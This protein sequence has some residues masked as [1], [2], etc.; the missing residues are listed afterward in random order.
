MRWLIGLLAVVLTGGCVSG[1]S[2]APSRPTSAAID[3]EAPRLMTA[4]GARGLAIA[5]VTDG[6]IDHVQAYGER[7]AAGQLLGPDTVMYGASLTKAVFAYTVMQLVDEGKIDLDRSIADYLPRP[8]PEY[9]DEAIEDR[10]ADFR[11]L[12][13]DPRWR[14]LTPRM[15]LTHSGGFANFGF[16]EPDGKLRIHFDPGTRY[17]YS[18]DGMILL[19]FVLEQGLGLGLGAE[20]QRRVF[21]QFDMAN[22]SMTWRA[23]F[24]DDLADGWMLDG[25]VEPHD[26]RSTARAAGSMDTTIT[27]FARFSAGF[28]QGQGLSPTARAE[29]TRPQRAITTR[30]HFPTLQPELPPEQRRP[31]LS[32][33]L[34]VVIFDGPQGRGFYKG[35]HNDST[36]NTWV[37]LETGRRCVIILSNDVR[38][39]PAFPALVRFVLGET[40]APWTWEY[41]PEA[42]ALR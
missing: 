2:A 11:G 28:M 33:G 24:A 14:A 4:T 9:Y 30:G 35:G 22:T 42:E 3:A 8:L 26:E 18:G 39:E 41:G 32:A 37:C 13:D 40:G 7:N 10:Y 16:L 6:Q 25:S 15:L 12:A 1:P 21:D 19:Q 20:M 17:A 38:S 5:V 23:D 36:G 29:I 27:D 34:G 31:D